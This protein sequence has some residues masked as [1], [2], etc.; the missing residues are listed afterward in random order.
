MQERVTSPVNRRAIQRGETSDRARRWSVRRRLV[1]G[2]ADDDGPAT[3]A[4]NV[5]HRVVL[6]CEREQPFS[7]KGRRRRVASK[8][9]ALRFLGRE[10]CRALSM[11]RS[12][13]AF[14]GR[15]RQYE[16]REA[17]DE[18]R[19][20]DDDEY[21]RERDAFHTRS[22]LLRRWQDWT[23]K[24][25]PRPRRPGATGASHWHRDG[26]PARRVQRLG[27]NSPTNERVQRE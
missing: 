8:P 20:E 7:L 13:G 12:G 15:A 6:R 3:R 22:P 21:P 5:H 4:G 23:S 25:R 18:G 19:G 24:I 1:R 27:V 26:D 17:S 10:D 2:R 16:E 9:S 14:I 11:Y